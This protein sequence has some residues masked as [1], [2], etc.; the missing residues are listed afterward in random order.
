MPIKF[1]WGRYSKDTRQK[2]KFKKENITKA[3]GKL[4]KRDKDVT[5]NT[6]EAVWL[7]I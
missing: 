7:L 1:M 2:K 6:R 3:N 4:A 5:K